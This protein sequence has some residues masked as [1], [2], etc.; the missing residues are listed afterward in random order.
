[1][2]RSTSPIR[3]PPLAHRVIGAAFAAALLSG[4]IATS[5]VAMPAIA[6]A[7]V[8]SDGDGLT[9]DFE[10]RGLTDPQNPDS[11]RD[12]L[13]DGDEFHKYYT[14]PTN[15]DSDDDGVSD[16]DEVLRYHTDPNYNP[17]QDPDSDGL[18]TPEE[19]DNHLDPQNPDSDRDGLLDGEEMRTYHT[20]P[21]NQ[22]TDD[23]DISDGDRSSGTT[24][25]RWCPT[26]NRRRRQLRRRRRR[27]RPLRHRPSRRTPTAT[28]SPM[29][30]RRPSTT[31]IP[32]A[33]TPITT[34]A[35]MASRSRTEP[36]NP[37]VPL[38]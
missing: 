33:R 19:L 1:M 38:I 7:S 11:D 18:E 35:P 3:T 4:G 9:D 13:S 17:G 5:V 30:T 2:S 26:P 20:G 34:D 28:A 31:P 16:G 25:I 23:D 8:D 37:R 36:T 22:D 21:L 14:G 32:T 15:Q 12:Y 29:T 10:L 6:S 24:R 27:H